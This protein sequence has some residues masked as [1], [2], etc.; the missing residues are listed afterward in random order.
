MRRKKILRR[1]E[2]KSRCEELRK[3][4]RIVTLN[5]SFDLLHAGH[6]KIIYEAAS[7]GDIL[8]VAL[9]S[10]SSIRGYKGKGRPIISLEDRMDMVASI[11]VVDFVTWFDELTPCN[12]LEIIR[13]D[14][15]VNGPEYGKECVEADVVKRYGGLVHIVEKV[16]SLSTSKIIEK[17]KCDL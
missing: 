13:P 10:D 17:I 15:H 8:I 9:N 11:E 6:L 4:N 7:L 16:P 1:E 14:I 3:V 2:L 12:I 5:G